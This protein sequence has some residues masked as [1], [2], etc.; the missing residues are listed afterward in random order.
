MSILYYGY[1]GG[2]NCS[3]LPA[4][5]GGNGEF[6]RNFLKIWEEIIQNDVSLGGSSTIKATLMVTIDNKP[7]S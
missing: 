7:P 3:S 5:L 6:E 1:R 2:F 4:E